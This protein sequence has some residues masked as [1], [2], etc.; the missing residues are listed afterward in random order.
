MKQ[1][2]G[3]LPNFNRQGGTD[4]LHK[5]KAIKRFVVFYILALG[6]FFYYFNAQKSVLL[7]WQGILN[8]LKYLSQ[9]LLTALIV[10]IIGHILWI[11]YLF[12]VKERKYPNSEDIQPEKE[13][14]F[15][16]IKDVKNTR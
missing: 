12:L 3:S 6:S 14:Y 9:H 2:H 8:F 7:N 16:H 15:I 11:L 10:T 4:I 5:V 1:Y 13:P